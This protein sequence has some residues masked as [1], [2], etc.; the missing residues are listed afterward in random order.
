[1]PVSPSNFG[2]T[3]FAF[4]VVEEG[5]GS[6]DHP[7]VDDVRDGVSYSSGAL[8]GTLTLPDEED[9]RDGVEYGGGGDEFTGTLTVPALPSG[10]D[11]PLAHS[12]AD[13]LRHLL[14]DLGYGETPPEPGNQATWPIFVS[15]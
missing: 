9:V 15:V 7:G 2:V 5:G 3:T 14:I 10:G 11:G 13:I 12:P 6:C 4:P 8:V 1:M